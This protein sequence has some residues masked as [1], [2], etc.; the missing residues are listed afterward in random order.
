MGVRELRDLYGAKSKFPA[1][2]K[3]AVSV[4]IPGGARVCAL[5]SA[6]SEAKKDRPDLEPIFAEIAAI[7][8]EMKAAIAQKYHF[9]GNQNDET[10]ESDH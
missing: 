5:K 10:N 4:E 8:D 1:V 6:L 2:M 9:K 3:R 7:Y